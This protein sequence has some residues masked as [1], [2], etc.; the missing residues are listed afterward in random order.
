MKLDGR[1]AAKTEMNQAAD[2]STMRAIVQDRYGPADV[3]R[4]ARIGR[5]VIADHEALLDNPTDAA[6]TSRAITAVADAARTGT[7]L[8]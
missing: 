2:E 8:N 4:P 5:P 3:L 6:T 7:S 1:K